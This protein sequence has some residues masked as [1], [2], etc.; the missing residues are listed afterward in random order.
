MLA[1]AGPAWFEDVTDQVG[2]DFVQGPGPTGA[3][4]M[5][6]VKGSGCG[7]I[8]EP[9]GTL[10]VY[11]LNSAGPRA[12]AVN[13]LYRW[14]PDGKSGRFQDVTDG[15][16]LGVAGWSKGV[17][18]GDVNNDGLP[19]VLLTQYGGVK[20]FLNKGGGQVRRRDA[21]GRPE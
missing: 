16:G 19:D 4:F 3:Y 2:L 13:R 9:D 1:A 11:L 20:L 10:Y 8:H 5:P 6:Q 18:V 15:S 21:G 17:A 7:V 14:V 12:Q